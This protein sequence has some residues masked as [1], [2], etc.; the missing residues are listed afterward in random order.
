MG[1]QV[2]VRTTL[3]T[4]REHKIGNLLE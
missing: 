2:L 1:V 3:W 4:Y